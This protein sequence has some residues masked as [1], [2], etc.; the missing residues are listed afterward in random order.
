[1]KLEEILA[2]VSGG[3]GIVESRLRDWAEAAGDF[4]RAGDLPVA[5]EAI[6][7]IVAAGAR[8]SQAFP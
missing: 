5:S 3:L 8:R 7:H 4:S 6:N 2:P 1:M